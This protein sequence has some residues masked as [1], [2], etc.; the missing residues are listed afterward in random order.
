MYLLSTTHRHDVPDMTKRLSHPLRATRAPLPP[1][2]R[3]R[4]GRFNVVATRNHCS[5]TAASQ[6][7]ASP[8]ETVGCPNTAVTGFYQSDFSSPHVHLPG[9]S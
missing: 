6:F 5:L 9:V 4:Q 2:P 1:N 8:H 3:G 7:E